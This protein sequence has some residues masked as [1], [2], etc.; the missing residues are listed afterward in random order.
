MSMDDRLE[1]IVIDIFIDRQTKRMIRSYLG[2]ERWIF[3]GYLD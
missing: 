2:G 3:E 1:E